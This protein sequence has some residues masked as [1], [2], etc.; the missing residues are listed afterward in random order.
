MLD[1]YMRSNHQFGLPERSSK[2]LL[3]ETADTEPYRLY[4]LDVFPHTEWDPRTLYSG[5]PY[6]A[7]H[8]K[9]HDESVL[10]VSASETWVDLI[11]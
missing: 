10:W 7:G 5:I 1:V 3:A 9:G 11:D 8:S 2:F 6:L 4:S